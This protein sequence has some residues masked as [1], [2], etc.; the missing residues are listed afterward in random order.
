MPHT[1]LYYNNNDEE[2][3]NF[4][5]AS[6]STHTQPEVS[7]EDLKRELRIKRVLG[8]GTFGM[9]CLCT[10]RGKEWV[11][12]LPRDQTWDHNLDGATIEEAMS[13]DVTPRQKKRILRDFAIECSNAEAVLDAP[14]V[15][16]LRDQGHKRVGQRLEMLTDAEY[17]DVC[18][19]R[20]DWTRL[21]GYAHMH[22]VVHYDPKIPLLLSLPAEGTIEDLRVN[23]SEYMPDIPKQWLDIAWQLSEA[24]HFMLEYTELAHV[25]VKPANVLYVHRGNGRLHCWLSDY[26]DLYP[27]DTMAGPR[28]GTPMY[29]PDAA[30]RAA[31]QATNAELSLFEYYATLVDM[32]EVLCLDGFTTVYT[33]RY[34]QVIAQTV[35]AMP[36]S[37]EPLAAFFH[38]QNELRHHVVEA[39]YIANFSRISNQ[40]EDTRAWLSSALSSITEREEAAASSRSGGGRRLGVFAG[41]VR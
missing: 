18:Q 21:P 24:M 25:D 8:K 14:R 10:F 35:V 38:M 1:A 2:E 22:P 33:S 5:R 15:R 34:P 27:K 37:L 17:A 19:W 12:K 31:L 20:D 13:V 23:V 4:F 29:L 6:V 30:A 41:I 11:V 9:A 36:Y 28:Y 32:F 16:A 7:S 3:G 40:F 39:L 26:G